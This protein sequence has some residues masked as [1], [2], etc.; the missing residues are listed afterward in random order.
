MH[1][2]WK[3]VPFEQVLQ[4][5]LDSE[6]PLNPTYLYR[7][8]DI[9]PNELEA[10]RK[11]WLDIPLWRRQALMEDVEDLSARDTLL[12]FIDLGLLA[13]RDPDVRVRYS[14]VH[15]LWEYEDE[16]L[17]PL[18]LEILNN[19][20]EDADVRATAAG[21]LGRYVL[22]GETDEISAEK[23][24][25]IEEALLQVFHSETAD[26][27]RRSALEALGY[28]S[29]AEVPALIEHA[30]ASNDVQWMASALF[31]I[32]RSGDISWKP[33]VLAM[34]SH[35]SPL[36]RAEAARAVG[37][38]EIKDAVPQLLELLDDPDEQTR[39]NS[40]WSLSQIGGEGIRERLQQLYEESLDEQEIDFLEEALENLSFTEGTSLFPLFDF[41]TEEG[42]NLEFYDDFEDDEDMDD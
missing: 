8:S 39:M 37:E 24:H 31:A 7:L 33:K 40:I 2:N 42:D 23:L 3:K 27:I 21:A 38:L 32:S 36:V 10:L 34:L 5:F 25:R 41:P 19:I 18:F 15:M 22:A 16:L 26:N 14:A 12:S 6:K 17:I 35:K 29:R 4:A 13:V 1:S 30:Y 20:N 9:E 11:I 28:S